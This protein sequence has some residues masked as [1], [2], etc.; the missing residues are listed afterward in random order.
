M[1]DRL[2]WG[3]I[4]T[5]NIARQFAHG[6]R[7]SAIRS[8]LV[9]VG[10]RTMDAARSFAEMHAIPAAHNSYD[11]LLADANVQ[12]IYL[13]LPNS[14]HHEWTI[15]ALARANTCFAKNRSR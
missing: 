4:G 6:V 10:S 14:L 15:K 8:E 7:K 2:R 1:S 11:K 5:G 12:A 13:S 9:S 3:I